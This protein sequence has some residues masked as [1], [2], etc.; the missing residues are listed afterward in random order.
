MKKILLFSLLG[1]FALCATGCQSKEDTCCLVTISAN[2][3]ATIKSICL[4]KPHDDLWLGSAPGKYYIPYGKYVEIHF[5]VEYQ[6]SLGDTQ[7]L[8]GV[9]KSVGVGQAKELDIKVG[10]YYKKSSDKTPTPCV[11]VGGVRRD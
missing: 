10:S 6:S 3:D 7:H 1:L 5:E 11:W 8:R 9:E 2:S 4:E